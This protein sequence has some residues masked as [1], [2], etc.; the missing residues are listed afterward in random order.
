M[1][2]RLFRRSR[3]RL[4]LWYAGVTGIV[5]GLSG[6]G[7]YRA[8]I[9]A[10][11]V[12][13]EREIE[14]IAGTLHDSVEPLLPSSENPTTVLHQ[15][16]PELCLVGQPC[17]TTSTLIQRHTIGISDRSTYYI[18]LFDDR[19][20]LLGF[21]PNH[22]SEPAALTPNPWQTV[23][24][25]E[26]DRYRQFTIVLHRINP[27]DP[28]SSEWGYLQIG[29]SLA[30]FDAEVARTRRI[31]L[32]GLPLVLGLIAVSGWW[33]SGIAMQPIYHSYQ[34]QQ[35]FTADA[36]H[37]LRTPL[38]SLLATIESLRR[39]PPTSPEDATNLLSQIEKQG[40]RISHLIAE[41]LNLANLDRASSSPLQACC[42]NDIVSDLVEEFSELADEADLQLS[43]CI[44]QLSI[45]VM[46]NEQQ[47]YR[48]ISNLIANAIQ[49]T[50]AGGTVQVDLGWRDRT[51]YLKIE[52]TGIGLSPEDCKRI[53]DRFY[54]VDR[55]R[56]RQ[57]GGNGLGLAIARAIAQ[58][59]DG[60]LSVE[61]QLDRGS[62]FILKLPILSF[63][64][65]TQY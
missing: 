56:S 51:A 1:S 3:L 8:S 22:P 16:F 45:F 46:G 43:S 2:R 57:T 64:T 4:S 60:Q 5:F 9:Q 21:S 42:L 65:H 61:S 28:S 48:L 36:A 53:F 26:G 11:W 52:D 40:R 59:H 23:R 14:S 34:Q 50:L 13:L 15:I 24:L 17:D 12:A 27:Q 55:D 54:R 38:A 37:E 41:L 31:L 18:R 6:L 7:V 47:L 49:Y 10:R 19:G 33:L 25:P 44:P 58:L 32:L 39:V 20:N 63:G 62:T 30:P 29:R 35:Q